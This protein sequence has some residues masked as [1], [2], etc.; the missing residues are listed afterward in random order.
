MLIDGNSLL[1]RAFYAI[2]TSMMT[3]SGQVTN[4]VYGFTSM[5][6]TLWSDHTPDRVVVVFDL[7][8]PTFRH[9]MIPTYKANRRPTPE[10]LIQQQSLVREMIDILGVPIADAPG[11]EADDVIATLATQG[12]DA[13][14]D[15][16]IVTGDRD[17]FQLVEDPHIQV[18]YNRQGVT[19]YVM[20]NE[21]G[22]FKR[23]GV[24]P[25]D[26]VLY[27][28]LRGD[29]S[30]NLPG[31]RGV[32]EKTAAQIINEFGGL[33]EIFESTEKLAPRIR[34]NLVNSEELV[35]SNVHMMQL[36]R[37]VDMSKNLK[38]IT[39]RQIDV[40]DVRNFFDRLDFRSLYSRLSEMSEQCFN[41]VSFSEQVLDTLEPNLV[42][43][44][45]ANEAIDL[46]NSLACEDNIREDNNRPL[47]FTASGCIGKGSKF[48]KRSTPQ[49][50]STQSEICSSS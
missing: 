41:G 44:A 23:T 40:E 4:A 35:R 2:P 14:E 22:I 15:V 48:Q 46:L 7:P 10:L 27:S 18:L 19:D 1:Y 34:K 45:N 49:M 33:E 39:M 42:T 17:S 24:K 32:G 26:Y 36:V 9:K 11:F 13:N 38:D 3:A 30:D 25:S 47:A 50:R 31:V 8:I 28:A 43:C 37:D 5:L 16:I 6:L 29:L 20:Y 21:K 12:R